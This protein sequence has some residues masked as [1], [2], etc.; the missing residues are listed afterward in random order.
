MWVL[1]TV[2]RNAYPKTGKAINIQESIAKELVDSGLAE[3][4]D[5]PDATLNEDEEPIIIEDD[6]ETE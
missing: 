2:G 1:T 5:G 3:Y 4:V 6:L